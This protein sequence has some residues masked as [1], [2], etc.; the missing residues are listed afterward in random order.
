MS[1]LEHA[2]AKSKRADIEPANLAQNFGGWPERIAAKWRESVESVIAAGNLIIE[3]KAAL[4]HGE[5]ESMIEG[6]LPFGASTA[7]RLIA[8]AKD[9]RISNRAHVHVLPAAWGTLYELTKLDDDQF[10]SGIAD[11]TIRPDLERAEVTALRKAAARAP[12]QAAYTARV[13]A[14]CTLDDLNALADSGARFGAISG[15]P[16][17]PYETWSAKG[18]DRSPDRHYDT[19]PLSE[20]KALP[21]K[22]LA[23]DDSVLH[24]WCMDWLLPCAL[25]VI[26]EWG[27]RFIKVGFVWVKQNPSGDGLFMGLGKWTREGT[28]LCLFA[29]RGNPSRLN[30]DVRQVIESPI[31]EHSRKPDEIHARIERL[32]AGP[33]LELYGRQPRDGWTVW[34]DEIP[35]VSFKFLATDHEA[36]PKEI[37]Q[38]DDGLDIPAFLRRGDQACIFDE[39]GIGAVSRETLRAESSQ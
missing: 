21:V 10:S 15:D 11:G 25:E 29:T 18:K 13:A 7:R 22:R 36:D 16:N 5:F 23:A 19:D 4:S 27:F 12:A 32:S 38:T 31:R 17:W 35:R 1:D 9:P 8:I 2:G 14:G 34:G 26:E 30:A 33:Y 6:A 24:L 37:S 28:E 3:A 20:I 39:K